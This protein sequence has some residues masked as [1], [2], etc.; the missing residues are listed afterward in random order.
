MQSSDRVLAKRYAQA[1]FLSASD[2]KNGADALKQQL[3]EAFKAL[4]PDLQVLK[5]PTLGAAAKKSLLRKK[6]GSAPPKIFHFMELL[7]DKK[8]VALLPLITSDL[9]RIVDENA[10]RVRAQVRSAAELGAEDYKTLTR[11]LEKFSGKEVAA[12][13]KV[14]PSLLGGVVV[15]MGDYVLDGSLLGK[16]RQLATRLAEE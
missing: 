11:K 2:D 7:I 15:R 1:L 9:A 5:S 12:E 10:G 6:I 3:G 14:D 8:R 16:L 13:V 4:S